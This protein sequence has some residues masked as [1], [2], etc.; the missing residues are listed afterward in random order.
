MF[1]TKCRNIVFEYTVMQRDIS[2]LLTLYIRN[3]NVNVDK[4]IVAI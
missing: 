2:Q 3:N 1:D 4:R